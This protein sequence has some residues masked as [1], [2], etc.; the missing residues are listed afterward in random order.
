MSRR[1][2]RGVQAVRVN[3]KRLEKEIAGTITN[4]GVFAI[5]REGT[6]MAATMTP[7]DTGNLINSHFAAIKQEGNRVVG[8]SGYTA[9]YAEFVHD[10]PGTLKGQSRPDNRGKYWA[11]SGEP[12]FLKK[13]FDE[14]KPRVIDILKEIYKK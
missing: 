8:H 14:I 1:V 13:G 10:A 5:L 11:P 2:N 3:L 9:D 12:E 7:V 6:A 4:R